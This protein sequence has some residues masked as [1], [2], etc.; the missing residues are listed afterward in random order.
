MFG[1][2]PKRPLPSTSK[3]LEAEKRKGFSVELGSSLLLIECLV[4]INAVVNGGVSR[5]G[6]NRRAKQ[7]ALGRLTTNSSARGPALPG[8]KMANSGPEGCQASGFFSDFCFLRFFS[9]LQVDLSRESQIVHLIFAK[10]K[11]LECLLSRSD[12]V[13]EGAWD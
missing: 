4:T 3:H 9:L 13:A 11:S 7:A 2:L 1:V 12:G 10:F 8:S 5:A 6:Q